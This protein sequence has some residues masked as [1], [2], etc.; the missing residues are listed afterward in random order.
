MNLAVEEAGV[1]ASLKGEEIKAR[2]KGAGGGPPLQADRVSLA[3]EI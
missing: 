2:S 1:S 3:R